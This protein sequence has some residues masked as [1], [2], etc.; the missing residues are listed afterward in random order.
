MLC[1]PANKKNDWGLHMHDKCP[2]CESPRFKVRHLTGGRMR[3]TPQRPYYDFGIANILQTLARD[4]E[5]CARQ[6]AGVHGPEQVPF[7]RSPKARRLN[8]CTDQCSEGCQGH[9]QLLD[10]SF[11]T[12]WE[13]GGD[14]G[15]MFVTAQ[16]ST[17]LISIRCASLPYNDKGHRAWTMPLLIISGPKEATNFKPYLYETVQFF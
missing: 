3:L 10:A 7:L 5:F 14:A 8:G 6:P 12:F 16:H 13:I 11:N 15:Q 2:K 17:V 4:P 9:N 1:L